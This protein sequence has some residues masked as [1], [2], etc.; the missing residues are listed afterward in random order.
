[1]DNW[2][3]ARVTTCFMR[4]LCKELRW[5]NIIRVALSPWILNGVG[6]LIVLV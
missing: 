4:E 3:V 5:V 2:Y 1:M 6:P